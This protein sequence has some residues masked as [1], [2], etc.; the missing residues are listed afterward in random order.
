MNVGKWKVFVVQL[1]LTDFF[2]I[3]SNRGIVFS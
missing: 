3:F 2:S 1:L